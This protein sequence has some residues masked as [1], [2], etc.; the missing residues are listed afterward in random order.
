[1]WKCWDHF[2]EVLINGEMGMWLGKSPTGALKGLTLSSDSPNELAKSLK[3]SMVLCEM[4][5]LWNGWREDEKAVQLSMSLSGTASQAWADSF[6]DPQAS[7]GCDSLVSAPTQCFK[8]VGHEE[9]YKAE[10][11]GKT[12]NREESFLEFDHRLRRLV[13]R[14]FPKIIH[15][16]RKELVMD[17]FLMGLTDAEMRRHMSLAHPRTQSWSGNH[18]GHR[19][20][21]PN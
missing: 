7:L 17:Q 14:A 12:K 3:C 9:A 21:D 11:R 8:P 15:E 19:I 1:M 18:T 2:G 16:S 5:S 4:V 13:I 10:F 6:C 20:W